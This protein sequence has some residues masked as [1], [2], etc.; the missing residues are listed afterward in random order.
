MA[1]VRT[2]IAGTFSGT[3]ATSNDVIVTKRGRL[4]LSFAGTATVELQEYS[5]Q[6]DAW[7]TSESFTGSTTQVVDGGGQRMRLNC[8][9]HTNNVVY[10][11]HGAA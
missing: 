9:A 1:T 10:E 4:K 2:Q 3:G 5:Q 7:I 11:L 6:A 8:S